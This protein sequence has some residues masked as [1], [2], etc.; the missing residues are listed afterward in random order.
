M[1]SGARRFALLVPVLN[2]VS[3]AGWLTLG[4]F[5]RFRSLCR[6]TQKMTRGCKPHELPMGVTS[7]EQWESIV[8]KKN[9]TS[10]DEIVVV[11]PFPQRLRTFWLQDSRGHFQ[12][13]ITARR[14][15]LCFQGGR[16]LP[17]EKAPY[18]K[19]LTG[20]EEIETDAIV[21]QSVIDAWLSAG[22]LHTLR[23]LFSG[24]E[25]QDSP[26]THLDPTR[27][28]WLHLNTDANIFITAPVHTLGITMGE[29]SML[30]AHWC[31][32]CKVLDLT[33]IGNIE[34]FFSDADAHCWGLGP[35]RNIEELVFK[36][37]QT[38]PNCDPR[39]FDHDFVH[40]FPSVTVIRASGSPDGE[41]NCWA[42]ENFP[43][44]KRI[45]QQDN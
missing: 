38:M 19:H 40:V 15:K 8:G 2:Q 25:W 3:F 10:V 26:A 11:V 39:V 1:Q 35:F 23:L 7:F 17:W 12:S 21:P 28:T 24:D 32:L 30:K 37:G 14:W 20:A 27:L 33:S 44:L 6:A 29:N 13:R 22:T 41:F 18:L 9:R 5:L 31:T 16:L 42:R 36:T 34:R 43:R 4:D 45:V